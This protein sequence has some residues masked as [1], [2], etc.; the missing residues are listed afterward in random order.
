MTST[1]PTETTDPLVTGLSLD[2]EVISNWIT[3][4][5]DWI[6]NNLLSVNTAIQFAVILGAFVIGAVL[7]RIVLP[8][9][10]ATI[11]ALKIK[12]TISTVLHNM[13][14]L[15]GPFIA[16]NILFVT[17]IVIPGLGL[18]FNVTFIDVAMRLTAA[19]IIIRLAV[20]LVK[21]PFARN[22]IASIVW[23]IAALS[24]FGVLDDTAT[25]LDS[26]GITIRDYRLTALI[27]VK[28]II[29][30]LLLM[31]GAGALSRFVEK[32]LGRVPNMTSGSRVLITKITRMLLMVIAIIIGI[33]MAG[34]DLSVLAVFSGAIGLG[35]GFGLQ[36]GVSNLFTGIMLLMDR[37]VQPGDILELQ[38][39]TFGVVR[40]MGSRCTEVVTLD[41]RSFLIPNEDLVTKPV[42]NWSRGGANSVLTIKF[43]VDYRHDPHAVIAIAV[44]VANA[45]PRVLR[46]PAPG[47]GLDGFGDSGMDMSLA[48]WIADPQNGTGN[49][50]SDIR[51]ALWTA[52]KKNK[53]IIP[54]PHQVAVQA[55][56]S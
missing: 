31:Y 47:C 26:V 37:T 4:A 43:R 22:L 36:R 17:L 24:I 28:C 45:H 33:T 49:V 50:Q 39:G 15:V 14:R 38:G 44:A 40:Q 41:R 30:T 2:E 54:Y 16:L 42:I 32:Q 19:W 27:L 35:V 34:V 20:Q 48:F 56:G 12:G 10:T 55:E 18:D 51:L 1:P 6:T 7:E 21:N 46:D 13:R 53:I 9:L 23:L 11:E 52:F 8:Y 3:A 5:Q 25:A 29:A